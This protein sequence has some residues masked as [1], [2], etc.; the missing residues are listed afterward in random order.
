MQR[1]YGVI[2]TENTITERIMRTTRLLLTLLCFWLGLMP[3][4]AQSVKITKELTHVQMAS[5]LAM[6]KNEFG[7]FEKPDLIDTFPYAVIRMHLEGNAKERLTLYVGQQFR[8]EARVTTYSN[9]ILFLVRAKRLLTYID[10]GD[11]CDQVLLSNMQQLR[12]NC[13]YDC[14]VRFT[15]ERDGNVITD[16]VFVNQ[17]PQYYDFKLRV[18][19]ADAKVEVIAHGEEKQWILTDGIADLQLTKGEYRYTISAEDYYPAQGTI[20]IPTTQTDTTIRLIPKFG[21][22]S[23]NCDSIHLQGL[24][25]VISHNGKGKQDTEPLPMASTIYPPGYYTISI[26][27]ERFFPYEEIVTIEENK[28]TD[29]CPQLV[30]KVYKRNTFFLAEAGY[31]MNPSWGVGLMFGQV[32]GEVHQGCGVGWYIKGR[33]NFQFTKAEE[34]LMIE[35]GGTIDGEKPS[36]TSNQRTNELLLNVGLVLNFLNKQHPNR[37]KNSMF[38]L[39][40]GLGYGQ[41]A[42]S[43]EISDGRWFEYAPSRAKGLSFG[44]GLIGSIKGFTINAGINTIQAKYVEVE[45]GLGWTF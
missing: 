17:G 40:A 5:V 41:Y 20:Q 44:G 1:D 13:L 25:A 33:S 22:L 10:C 12:S 4:A 11:G 32:Y 6:Y 45:A 31:A 27:K 34:G 29:V 19:P 30:R 8:V 37:S 43:W 24:T 9:Q 21:W 14:T 28:T 42:R 35:E 36:Y 38:G 39:Y 18:E 7:S 23:I 2:N 3:L 16:T 26:N 15:P